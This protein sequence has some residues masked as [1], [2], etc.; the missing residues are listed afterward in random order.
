MKGWMFVAEDRIYRVAGEA[1]VFPDRAYIQFDRIYPDQTYPTPG[2]FPAP[3]CAVAVSERGT[4][5]GVYTHE[6]V[7]IR[8]VEVDPA[9]VDH[10]PDAAILNFSRVTVY[11]QLPGRRFT[12]TK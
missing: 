4:Q 7:Q 3:L 12:E 9:R 10:S 8:G 1:K 6:A 2:R 11:V 5:F